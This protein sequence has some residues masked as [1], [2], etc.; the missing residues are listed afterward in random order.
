LLHLWRLP[1]SGWMAIPIY[2]SPSAYAAATRAAGGLIALV[3]AIMRGRVDNGFA[4]VR[5]PVH[6]ALAAR[7]M[8]FCLFNNVAIA[9]AY[10]LALFASFAPLREPSL[11][12]VSR[13]N[14][15]RRWSGD[16]AEQM[17]GRETLPN[18]WVVRRPCRTDGWSG[19]LAEQMGGRETLPNRWVV[20]RPCRTDG[21]SGDLAEQMGDR[22]T[23]PN[24]WF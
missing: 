22:E 9:A 24:R 8:G 10:S 23:L 7:G 13:P 4:L 6:H 21:W 11:E 18:R 19:D 14:P 2:I 3:D 1:K 17:G 15:K 12:E 20:R 5:P 16:L